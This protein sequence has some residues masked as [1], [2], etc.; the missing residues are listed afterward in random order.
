MASDARFQ[1]VHKSARLAALQNTG[2]SVAH[3]P[4]V[5]DGAASACGLSGARFMEI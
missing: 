4:L 1:G 2:L 3:L 5:L